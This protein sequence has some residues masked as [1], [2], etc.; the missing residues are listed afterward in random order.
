ML[1]SLKFSGIYSLALDKKC[2]NNC[3]FLVK[4]RK[5]DICLP[6]SKNLYLQFAYWL[7]QKIQFACHPL[8]L[9]A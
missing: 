9:S 7:I 6:F 4:K 5:F 8:S 3:I 2:Y 1:Q